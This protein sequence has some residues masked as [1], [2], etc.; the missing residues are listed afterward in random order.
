MGRINMD[1]K[2]RFIFSPLGL[3]YEAA[4]F[5]SMEINGRY[6]KSRTTSFATR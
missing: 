5:L 3:E 1:A 4:D 2:S 6:V